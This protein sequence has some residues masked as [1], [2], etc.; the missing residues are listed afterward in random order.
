[1]S[2]SH[3]GDSIFGSP[4]RGER[5]EPLAKSGSASR[6]DPDTDPTGPVPPPP[7]RRL[8]QPRPTPQDEARQREQLQTERLVAPAAA[9]VP[10]ASDPVEPPT[11][12]RGVRRA[13]PRS[14]R[15]DERGRGPAVRGCLVLVVVALVAGA[16][17]LFAIST[18]GSSFLPKFGGIAGGSGG[19]DYSGS[20]KEAVS[21]TIAPG[22]FG[23]EIG[24]NLQKAGV[25]KSASTFTALAAQNPKFATLQPG[26]YQLRKQMSS[27]DALALLVSPAA[28][29]SG[30]VTIP[31]GLWAKE[32]Y[33]R[34]AAATK[35][36]VADYGKV[37]TSSLGLPAAAGGKVEGYLFP[38]T[39]EFPKGSSAASQLKAMVTRF[40]KEAATLNISDQKLAQ[41]TTVASLVQAEASRPQDDGKV[42][43]VI[44]NRLAQKMPLQ[45]DSTVNYVLQKRGSV[46][47]SDKARESKSPYNTYGSPGLPP[48]PINSPGI[49]ALKAALNPTP[50]NWLYFVTVD[51]GTGQ[52]KFAKSLAEHNA[53]V[54]QFQAWCKRNP[55]K[56]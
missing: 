28:K 16:A 27:A 41:V 34:L 49:P 14:R 43:R 36:P 17:L 33:T 10:D 9:S 42:A 22:D 21:I 2:D 13:G 4:G 6:S 18:V 39:Y 5:Q 20:G 24:A 26:V 11:G 54:Q 32:V 45:L 25:V 50:G 15:P 12:S 47:T 37:P 52:T 3:F 30:G 40:K 38:S 35:V 29:I 48:G 46:T 53:N 44:D 8:N 1:M 7:P 55:G 23:A 56:C 51:L 19:G 31:E